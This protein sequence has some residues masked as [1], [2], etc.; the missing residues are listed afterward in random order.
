MTT[1]YGQRA[2]T[3]MFSLGTHDSAHE[4]V[5][6]TCAIIYRHTIAVLVPSMNDGQFATQSD[7]CTLGGSVGLPSRCTHISS[8]SISTYTDLMHAHT[9]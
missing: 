7:D 2:L 5:S 6:H 1:T 3:R 9:R 4:E 8:A